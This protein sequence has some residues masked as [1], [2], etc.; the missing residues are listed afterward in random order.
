MKVPPPQKYT[1]PRAGGSSSVSVEPAPR[2][3]RTSS[4]YA[5]SSRRFSHHHN[6]QDEIPSEDDDEIGDD[7]EDISDGE[8]LSRRNDRLYWDSPYHQKSWRQT[9]QRGY[10]RKQAALKV[11]YSI[12]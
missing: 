7:N 12:G 1:R 5:S 2:S 10:D 11:R 6:R 9:R 8:Q 4:H 3:G